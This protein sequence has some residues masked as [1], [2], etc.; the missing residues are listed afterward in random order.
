MKAAIHPEYKLTTVTCACG[1]TFET[2][3]TKENIRVDICSAC[4]PFF[5]GEQK[6]V[7]KGGRVD[8]FKKKYN[9]K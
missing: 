1:N 7:Y 2:G 5:T 9:F 6:T 4:H 8:R 3:S